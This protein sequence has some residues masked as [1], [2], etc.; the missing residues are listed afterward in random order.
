MN[1]VIE[2]VRRLAADDSTQ[3]PLPGDGATAERLRTLYEVAR[4][5]PIGVAR[6]VEAHTDAVAILAEAGRPAAASTVYG[7][8]ASQHRGSGVV[9]DRHDGSI[10]GTMGFASGLGLIDRALVTASSDDGIVL[11][12]TVLDW[13]RGRIRADP[14]AWRSPALLD[15]RT[16]PVT[17]HRHP[18]AASDVV[19]AP[20]WYL[21]RVGFWHGAC[22]PAACW[23]GGAAGLVDR[24]TELVDDDPHRLA[25][26]GALLA[27]RWTSRSLLDAA[28]DQIDADPTSP[29]T[30][31][32]TARSLRFAVATICRDVLDRFGRAFGPRPHVSD[33]SI[34][35]RAIDLDMY[36]RQHHA[37]RELGAIAAL[38]R[39]GRH[40]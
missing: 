39:A 22:A 25:H 20:G 30:A 12:D 8:W 35:Q 38:P 23:A 13:G 29:L 33:R 34:A 36:I 9:H 40:G 16:G 7:V 18:V 32:H 37:E 27:N 5:H 6:L 2:L 26:L 15:T 14:G 17:F 10:S 21:D 31:E 4:A 28:G 1:E 11:I 24:A 3:L 19:A